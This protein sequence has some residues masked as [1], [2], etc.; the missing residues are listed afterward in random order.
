M[1]HGSVWAHPRSVVLRVVDL[2]TSPCLSPM[3][4]LQERPGLP[5]QVL[6]ASVK[7]SLLNVSLHRT[8]HTWE[9]RTLEEPFL[10]TQRLFAFR[11]GLR[12]FFPQPRKNKTFRV[13]LVSNKNNSSVENVCTT[14]K[15]KICENGYLTVESKQ[16]PPWFPQSEQF[17]SYDS[18]RAPL[19]GTC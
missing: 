14:L 11:V 16:H 6:A 15:K 17:P 7:N 1:L 12:H 8:E 19:C 10:C 2:A 18:A 9:T 13:D 5:F 3:L 4:L